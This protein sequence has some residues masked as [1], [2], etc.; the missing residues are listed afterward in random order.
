MWDTLLG[1]SDLCLCS[2]YQS[3]LF[4]WQSIYCMHNPCKTVFSSTESM[5]DSTLQTMLSQVKI[6]TIAADLES[7]LCVPFLLVSIKLVRYHIDLAHLNSKNC[8]RYQIVWF[9]ASLRIL[10]TMTIETQT[11]VSNLISIIVWDSG[12]GGEE[13]EAGRDDEEWGEEGG[14]EE[15][16]TFKFND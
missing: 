14:E 1:W 2:A 11:N 16:I 9:C 5:S 6:S 3:F 15:G 10:A 13:H 8:P 12:K 4:A 7:T